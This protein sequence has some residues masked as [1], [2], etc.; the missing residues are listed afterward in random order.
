[1]PKLIRLYI[2]H[3]IIG[4]A[5]AAAFVAMLL[6]FNV[7][8]L[9]H[10]VTHSDVGLLAVF[11]LWLSNGF[12]FAG[13]QFAIAVMNLKDSDDDDHGGKRDAIR[14]DLTRLVPVRA[15]AKAKATGKRR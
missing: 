4:Y 14:V 2:T 10:L 5:I 9:W 12:V 11:I 6:Y 1:M 13:V 15:A 8:N 3:V 7:A